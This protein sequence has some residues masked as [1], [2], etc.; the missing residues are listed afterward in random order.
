MKI[1]N[2]NFILV[3]RVDNF[4]SNSWI[5]TRSCT[6]YSLSIFYQVK[7]F[8]A[9]KDWDTSSFWTSKFLDQRKDQRPSKKK[10]KKGLIN[11]GQALIN[12]M[13]AYDLIEQIDSSLVLEKNGQ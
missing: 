10:K 3:S 5:I 9:A 12:V 1:Y 6:S 8:P 7:I 11:V 4:L 13:L 2:S